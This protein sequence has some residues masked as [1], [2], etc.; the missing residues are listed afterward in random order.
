MPPFPT[1]QTSPYPVT[2]KVPTD[3][4]SRLLGNTAVQV[5]LGAV[6]AVYGGISSR[7]G[8]ALGLTL[9]TIMRLPQNI[10]ENILTPY[11]SLEDFKKRANSEGEREPTFVD[12][13]A[14]TMSPTEAALKTIFPT[15]EE[16][17]GYDPVLPKTFIDAKQA[18]AEEGKNFAEQILAGW[19]AA[20]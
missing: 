2:P 6:G 18:A 20:K 15:A 8:T 7:S 12:G 9:E 13:T 4:L 3:L 5:G 10:R 16:L 19:G 14:P 17:T 1:T 11:Q